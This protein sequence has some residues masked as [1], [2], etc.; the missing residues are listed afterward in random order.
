MVLFQQPLQQKE[1]DRVV[2]AVR[3]P[4]TISHLYEWNSTVTPYSINRIQNVVLTTTQTGATRPQTAFPGNKSTNLTVIPISIEIFD[5]DSTLPTA[6]FSPSLTSSHRDDS[7]TNLFPL[8]WRKNPLNYLFERTICSWWVLIVV[9][10]EGNHS[11]VI[12]F[13]EKCPSSKTINL[14]P[15]NPL[16]SFAVDSA[17]CTISTNALFICFC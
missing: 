1:Y 5:L 11:Y 3:F 2:A 9:G 15:E 7:A 10:L 4:E 8:T 16:K 12:P 6:R 17:K 13:P 14:E